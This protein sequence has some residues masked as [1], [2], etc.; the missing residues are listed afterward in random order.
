VE[1]IGSNELK[2][3]LPKNYAGTVTDIEHKSL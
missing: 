3:N 1:N 2:L